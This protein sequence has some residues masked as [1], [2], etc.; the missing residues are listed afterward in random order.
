LSWILGSL[1]ILLQL[2][3]LPSLSS[4]YTNLNLIRARAGLADKPAQ[5]DREIFFTDLMNERRWELIF[6][7]NLWMHYI[8]TKRAAKFFMSEYGLVYLDK[9]LKYPIPQIDRDLNPNLCQ[10]PGY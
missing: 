9:W 5:S 4:A 3:S 10:N 2:S 1:L 8:R 7:P 6:E